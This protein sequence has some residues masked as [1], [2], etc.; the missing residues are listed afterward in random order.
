MPPAPHP[1]PA[2]I[3]TYL[4]SLDAA[5]LAEA[6]AWIAKHVPPR[7]VWGWVA[8]ADEIGL[9]TTVARESAKRASDPLPIEVYEDRVWA[10]ASALRAWVRRQNRPYQEHLRM[11]EEAGDRRTAKTRAATQK[12]VGMRLAQKAGVAP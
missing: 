11:L 1:T 10:Y 8:I 5:G 9:G 7:K 12:R 4:S 6:E 3:A 2:E